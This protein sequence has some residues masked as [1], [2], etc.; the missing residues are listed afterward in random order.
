[1]KQS[2]A[3]YQFSVTATPDLDD[4]TRDIHY[5]PAPCQVACPIGTDAPS[6]I[7]YV[8]EGKNE[9]AMEAITATNPFSAICGRVCDAPCEP[10]CR[11][12]DSD[13]AIAIRNL[14]RYVLEALGPGFALPPVAVTRDKTVGIVGAGP[15]GLTAAHDLAEDGYEVH[16]YEATDK[17]GGMMFW[18]IPRFRLPEIAVQ[19]DI[20]RMMAHCPGIKVHLNTAL[21]EQVTLDELKQK[22]DSVLLSIGAFVGKPMGVAGDFCVAPRRRCAEASTPRRAWNSPRKTHRRTAPDFSAG[23]LVWRRPLRA[24]RAGFEAPRRRL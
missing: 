15:A 14:K 18:G 2:E 16:V 4:D 10:A 11:R 21:G 3:D 5:V 17:L 1:M 9:E 23:P 19:Q 7:A 12:A 8:W 24:P 20:D 6:Y 13:G 22:H